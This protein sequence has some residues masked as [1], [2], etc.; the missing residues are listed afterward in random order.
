MQKGQAMRFMMA[1]LAV[2]VVLG[3]A[4]A[5][6][7]KATTNE[8]TVGGSAW[9]SPYGGSGYGMGDAGGYYYP[10][11]ASTPFEG[12]AYGLGRIIRAEGEYNLDTSKAA[13]NFTEAQ[14]RE[15]ENMQKWT[16]TYFEL[17]RLN[18]EFRVAERGRRPTEADFVR[19]AQMG[20][21]RRLGPSDL[22][23]VTGEIAWPVLLR[24]PD[25]DPYRTAV[26][27]VFSQRA[28]SGIIGTVEY[29][30]VYQVTSLM[31]DDLRRHI[32]EVPPNDY[33]IA[34]RFLESLAYEARLPAI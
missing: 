10:E 11:F 29:L 2:A 13:I 12:F 3:A 33:V 23:A 25:L 17:R 26:E 9:F 7:Q 21:P 30:R 8:L 4:V 18:R 19:Y 34:R 1:V 20:K 24:T 15:M 31:L 6:A 22:D 14:R 5:S 32:H 28:S 16:E 27:Q